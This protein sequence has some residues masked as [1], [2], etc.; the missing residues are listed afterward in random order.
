MKLSA[1]SYTSTNPLQGTFENVIVEDIKITHKKLDKY[2]AITFEMSYLNNGE[3]VVLDT[4]DMAFLGMNGDQDTTNVTATFSIPNPDYN[5]AIEGSEQRMIVPMIAYLQQHQGIFPEDFVM[6]NWGFPTFEDAITYFIGGNLEVQNISISNTFAAQ[7]F[8][9][10]FEI[11]GEKIGAQ[12]TFDE[13][14]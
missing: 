14:R 11:N 12:F 3:K 4:K 1:Q 2:L 13:L 5:A 9:N 7:W 8:L 6:V 10:T